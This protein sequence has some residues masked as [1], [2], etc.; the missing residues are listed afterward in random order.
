MAAIT[1]S[2]LSTGTVRRVSAESHQI[3]AIAPYTID[4]TNNAIIAKSDVLI[5]D[6]SV[7]MKRVEETPTAGQYSITDNT[8]TFSS[9][10]SSKYVYVDYFYEDDS[11]GYC[12]SIDPYALPGSFKL[13]TSLKAYDTNSADYSG[14]VV[15]VASKCRRSGPIEVGSRVGEFGTFGFDFTV[16]NRSQDDVVLYF[17]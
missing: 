14:D 6:D 15:F 1:G 8:L 10:D 11:D 5:R 3:P 9:A 12:L 7:R 2:T 4:L 16:E 13:I 17:P